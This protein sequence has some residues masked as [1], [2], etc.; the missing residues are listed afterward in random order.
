MIAGEERNMMW[1]QQLED[2]ATDKEPACIR[3]SAR[4][5]ITCQIIINPD[6]SKQKKKD[7]SFPS[8]FSPLLDFRFPDGVLG[9]A[10]AAQELSATPNSAA[11]AFEGSELS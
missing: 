3:P 5:L 1:A 2:R 8:P 7:S 11:Y 10:G 4:S 9:V 6:K